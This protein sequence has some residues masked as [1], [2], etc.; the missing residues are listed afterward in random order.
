MS[1]L[2]KFRATRLY[3][4]QSTSRSLV[5][6]SS[7]QIRGDVLPPLS[8]MPTGLLLRSLMIT[9]ILSSRRLLEFSLPI[10]GR[11]A[12]SNSTLANPDRN[13]LLHVL[14][15]RFLYDHFA[16]GETK[17]QV[18]RTVI[19]IK[20]MGFTGVILGYARETIAQSGTEVQK[21]SATPIGDW[22]NGTLR[23]LELIGDGDFLAI[24]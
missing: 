4:I 21:L 24:K 8:V 16:A 2:P 1:V 22:R 18:K 19:K 14:V 3:S 20:N 11:I 10:L 7:S 9:S 17:A 5:R 23:T 12:N 13:P 6:S 15:R